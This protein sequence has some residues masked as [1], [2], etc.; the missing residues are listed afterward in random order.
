MKISVF[1]LVLSLTFSLSSYSNDEIGRV[2]NL[3]GEVLRS[4]AEMGVQDQPLK[5]G[6]QLFVGDLLI[7]GQRSFARILMKDET[8]FQVGPETTFAVEKFDFKEKNDRQATYNL[9]AG[10]LRSVFTQKAKENDL[11]I[12]T[13]TASMGIRG[14][15]ILS[16]VYLMDGEVRTDIALLSGRLDVITPDANQALKKI[17]L[18]PGF[19]YETKIDL[20]QQIVQGSDARRLPQ[21]MLNQLRSPTS[22][23]GHTFLFDASVAA[24]PESRANAR[25]DLKVVASTDTE[26]KD[27]SNSILRVAPDSQPAPR[28]MKRVPAGQEIEVIPNQ[29]DVR[30]DDSARLKR[31]M[32]LFEK[33][34][35][36]QVKRDNP[37]AEKIVEKPVIE[38]NPRSDNV[39]KPMLSGAGEKKGFQQP[40]KIDV[41][42]RRM[43]E[44]PTKVD[45][46]REGAKESP[47]KIDV[48]QRR[49][50]EVPTKVDA[51][52]EGAQEG[53]IKIDAMQKRTTE[54]PP[55]IDVIRKVTDDRPVK[56][57]I[58]AVKTPDAPVMNLDRQTTQSFDQPIKPVPTA[59]FDNN[60]A[61]ILRGPT[62]VSQ[63]VVVNETIRNVDRVN[64]NVLKKSFV[65]EQERM[66][67]E[68]MIKEQE[69]V[70]KQ[71]TKTITQDPVI[72]TI[73]KQNRLP[74]SEPTEESS[75]TFF[76]RRR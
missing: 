27:R 25:F 74:A 75:N 44:V 10:R 39:R 15:E 35:A 54:S 53:T 66:A 60:Q 7:S 23:G 59:K 63:P 34:E 69:K 46:M 38:N 76:P 58:P 37:Q 40:E 1:F 24:A 3:R 26:T 50:A 5:P 12:K 20:K 36:I 70:I 43:A 6:A 42:Q 45:A 47:V 68:T 49:M 29:I 8:L 41:S 51:M 71:T 9:V 31:E 57:D 21:E 18:Q 73:N 55:K 22:A 17:S 30:E 11:Y 67:Q 2:V 48:S 4:N 32:P 61:T 16:D 28:E 33:I 14:T 72:D 65:K 64:D 19:V 13:P 52:R 62:T 56:L